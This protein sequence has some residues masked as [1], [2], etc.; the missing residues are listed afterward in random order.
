[1]NAGVHLSEKKME[2]GWGREEDGIR[3]EINLNEN[4]QGIGKKTVSKSSIPYSNPHSN[5]NLYITPM[6]TSAN[7]LHPYPHTNNNHQH[8][9]SLNICTNK[10]LSSK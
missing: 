7:N 4:N 5:G 6:T 8:P 2:R 10:L 3:E 9:Q 1:V